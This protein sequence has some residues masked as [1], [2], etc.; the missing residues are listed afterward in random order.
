MINP[1]SASTSGWERVSDSIM[2]MGALPSGWIFFHSGGACRF[3][4]LNVL[5]SYL[6]FNSSNSHRIRCDRDCSSL[7][8]RLAVYV[9]RSISGRTGIS[10]LKIECNIRDLI[11]KET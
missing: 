4:R 11:E 5:T 7:P 2:S 8:Q 9:C 1:D 10:Y 3:S 6:R